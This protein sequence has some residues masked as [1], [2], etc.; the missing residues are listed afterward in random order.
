MSKAYSSWKEAQEDDVLS[1]IRL[2]NSFK[3]LNDRQADFIKN[4]ELNK[5][6]IAAGSPGTGKTFVAAFYAIQKLKEGKFDKII[7]CRPAVTCGE[8]QGFLPGDIM[9]KMLPFFQP[10]L[11]IFSEI[12]GSSELERMVSE[13]KIEL[14]VLQYMRG[15]TIKNS[16]LIADEAQNLTFKQIKMLLTRI[17][18]GSKFILTGD[19]SQDDLNASDV[20]PLEDTIRRI[21]GHNDIG[22]VRFFREHIVRDPLIQYIDEKMSARW[23]VINNGDD[24]ADEVVVGNKTWFRINCPKCSSNVWFCEDEHTVDQ[25][26]CWKCESIIRIP[27]D[28]LK[29]LILEGCEDGY[30]FKGTESYRT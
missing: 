16:F 26:K 25:V 15:S 28:N 11:D 10:M 12:I 3:P 8:S 2:K 30:C 22:I 13:E 17:G 6:S 5:I 18:I 20:N 7:L 29:N 21:K 24:S 14:A 4:M 27:E 23:G 9:E 19:T 1:R